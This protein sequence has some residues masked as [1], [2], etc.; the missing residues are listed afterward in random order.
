[1]TTVEKIKEIE[2]VASK[3]V[4]LTSGWRCPKLRKIK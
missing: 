3:R 2:Y 4:T 1:M